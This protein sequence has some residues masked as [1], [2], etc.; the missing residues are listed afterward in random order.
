MT[1][2]RFFSYLTMVLMAPAKGLFWFAEEELYVIPSIITAVF[3][4][5]FFVSA[6]WADWGNGSVILALVLW[7]ICSGIVMAFVFLAYRLFEAICKILCYGP[8]CLFDNCKRY[9]ELT[10]RYIASG[11][12]EREKEW[13]R[14]EKEYKKQR[15]EQEKQKTLQYFI[16]QAKEPEINF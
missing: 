12:P 9:I 8:A 14:Q 11:A 7:A 5:M 3:S 2:K 6:F 15:K 4:V 16:N 13:K 1:V 10:N